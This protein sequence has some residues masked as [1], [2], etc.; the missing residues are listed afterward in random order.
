MAGLQTRAGPCTPRDAERRQHVDE[1]GAS[2]APRRRAQPSASD[3]NDGGSAGSRR[4]TGG[5]ATSLLT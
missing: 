1:P 3:A 2:L 4:V 5:Q